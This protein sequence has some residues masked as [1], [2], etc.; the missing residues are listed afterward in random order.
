MK[1]FMTFWGEKCQPSTL[2]LL[3]NLIVSCQI[4][5]STDAAVRRKMSSKL[6]CC[7]WSLLLSAAHSSMVSNSLRTGE[8]L[9]QNWRLLNGLSLS[10]LFYADDLVFISQWWWSAETTYIL[11]KYYE[12]WLLTINLKKT[13]TVIFQKQTRKSTREKHRFF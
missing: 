12:K 3:D 6:L 2:K 13:K 5:P 9:T 11:H 8:K 4:L 10:C 7:C 1:N